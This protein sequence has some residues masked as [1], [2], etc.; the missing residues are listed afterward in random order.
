MMV[1]GSCIQLL[2]GD[3]TELLL[4]EQLAISS[5]KVQGDAFIMTGIEGRVLVAVVGKCFGRATSPNHLEAP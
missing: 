1:S 3:E 4:L 2:S 5:V